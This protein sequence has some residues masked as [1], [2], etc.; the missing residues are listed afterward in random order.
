MIILFSGF[1]CHNLSVGMK[2][3]NNPIIGTL[4]AKYKTVQKKAEKSAVWRGIKE[5]TPIR[6]RDTIRTARNSEAIL[7]LNDGTEINLD[8][9]SMIRIDL[10]DKNINVDFE[11]GM[12]SVGGN[13]ELNV[14]NGS[15][16]L[17]DGDTIIRANKNDKV[18]V[19]E[20]ITS[21]RL[22]NP[23]PNQYF[24]TTDKKQ[25]IQFQWESDS[26]TTLEIAKNRSFTKTILKK[27]TK[28]SVY[29]AALD[30]GSYYWRVSEKDGDKTV[31]T[32]IRKFRIIQS[33]PIRL[34]SPQNKS[35]IN[36]VDKS[37]FV[38][39]SWRKNRLASSYKL[40]ISKDSNFNT[41]VYTSNT[42]GNF[43]GVKELKAGTYYAKVSQK[44]GVAGLDIETSP[45][46]SFRIIKKENPNPPQLYNPHNGITIDNKL[47]KNGKLLFNW[48]DKS[49][50]KKY[51]F[52]V[53]SDGS[54]NRLIYNRTL[55][56]NFIKE[57]M[58]TKIGK[59][60]FWRI[61]GKTSSGVESDFSKTYS[62]FI[63]AYEKLNLLYPKDNTTLY[64]QLNQNIQFSWQ[65]TNQ[66][67]I[68]LVEISTDK[69]FRNIIQSNK[70]TNVLVWLR[71]KDLGSYYWRVTQFVE[72]IELS[73]SRIHKFKIA[74]FLELPS[75]IYPI[76]GEKVELKKTKTL[77]F[78]WKKQDRVLYYTIELYD[79]EKQKLVYKLRSKNPK[80]IL[81]NYDNIQTGEYFWKLSAVYKGGKGNVV[82][83]PVKSNFKLIVP[84]EKFKIPEVYT[85]KKIYVE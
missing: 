10:D 59:K 27:S 16:N 54:F 31:Y 38:M 58:N 12:F 46:I 32:Q 82:S 76:K 37:P 9:N 28:N 51:M 69:G 67:G 77:V 33:K 53:S 70:T 22:Q 17:K 61:K 56:D 72:D 66:N 83:E 18:E 39:F 25:K 19:Q 11:Y 3:G 78:D 24:Q 62:F 74:K 29:E 84:E 36:Y 44:F 60:Y 35:S 75:P 14:K 41:V 50:F 1:L 57:K 47:L 63:K 21:I 73:Q 80:A 55:E 20:N 81:R 85:P 40:M 30:T 6:N 65:K 64:P 42:L 68:F 79:R 43:L 2:A 26:I 52:Q 7:K 13:G 23:K 15:T 4:V 48:E 5:S 49:Y 71:V 45:V 34:I 8:E